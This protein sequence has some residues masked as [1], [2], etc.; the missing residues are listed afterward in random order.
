MLRLRDG[1][2]G[3]FDA[4]AE[5]AE[6]LV[7]AG[8]DVKL[9][10]GHFE[11]DCLALAAGGAQIRVDYIVTFGA[12][13]DVVG[14]AEGVDLQRADVGGEEEEVLCGG[15][16]H[17]P[18]VEVEEGHEEVK[19]YGRDGGDDEVGEDIITDFKAACF[20]LNNYD[21]KGGEGVV[22]HYYAVG[23]HGAHIEPLCSLGPVTHCEDKLR[24]DEEDA[25]VAEDDE[26]YLSNTMAE[27][28]D[29]GIGQ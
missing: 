24:A 12:P 18:G 22:G 1:D 26:D 15:G 8:V 6:G 11:L 25:G 14:I 5:V 23:Y 27:R 3:D 10:G 20:E 4:I 16:K 13:G 7:V 2:G 9:F 21:V 19:A 29:Y 17:V 28:V